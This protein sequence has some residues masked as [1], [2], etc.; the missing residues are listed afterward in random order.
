LVTGGDD[1]EIV[2]TVAARDEAAVRRE[3]ERRHVRLT[4]IGR[5]VPGSGVAARFAGRAVSFAKTGFT[6]G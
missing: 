3:A 1:Y 5:V 2:F 6:H 4:Q